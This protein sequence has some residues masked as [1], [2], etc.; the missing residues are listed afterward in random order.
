VARA[1]SVRQKRFDLLGYR[2]LD[3]GDPIDWHLD[4]VAGRRAPFVHW[5]RLAP[6]DPGMVG[7]SKVVWELNRHQWLLHLGQA[8]RFTGDE[9]YA[10][11]FAALIRDWMRKNP[12]GMGI[13]WASSL[14]AAFRIISWS[15]ALFL[16]RRSAALSPELFVEM[17]GSICAHAEH[18]EKYLSIYFAP[19]THLT[20][21]AL[22]L[23]YA[24]LIYPELQSAERWRSLGMKILTEQSE[25][26]VLPD[27]VYFE[28]ATC[29]QLYT[30]EIYLHF[31]ILAARNG[32][33]VPKSI[34][35]KLVK[36]LDFLVAVRRPDGSIPQIGDGD[37]GWLLPLA[38]RTAE[39]FRGLF[40]QAAVWFNRAD[41]AWAA[42]GPAPEI[43]WILGS[44]GVD[45]FDR[46]QPCPPQA[47]PS[48][49]FRDGGY[50]VMRSSWK[51]DSH[52]LIFDGGPLGCPVTGGHGH[53]DLLSIQCSVFGEPYLVDPGTYCYT[54][55]QAWR[56]YFRSS[57]AHSTVLVDGMGQ[58][59]PA[60]P[61]RWKARPRARLRQWLS[62]ESY[63][64]AEAEHDAFHRLPDPV[65]HRRRV[66]FVKPRYWIVVDD[67]E[68]SA[69]HRVELRFQFA[70]M[71]VGL[72]PNLWSR[73]RGTKG[74]GL[75]IKPFAP[76]ML[77]AGIHQGMDSPMA[78]WF[79]PAYG[80]R[81]PAP[82]LCYSASARLPLRVLTLLL[83]IEDPLAPVP[84]VSS[85][86]DGGPGP[87]GLLFKEWN[88]RIV[89]HRRE[90]LLDRG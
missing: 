43:P 41:Y 38:R 13:N 12:P 15:W 87:V 76:V 26:Q 88:E 1:N 31:V 24:G 72:E 34:E 25:R 9:R 16:F 11:T 46:L 85:V 53:A 39:D 84:A 69:D 20:G 68:G 14:E 29:Y 56:D 55:S 17:L 66:I 37:T 35:E 71:D 74:H 45:D 54:A 4:P 65:T 3:F 70:P 48:V 42:G 81:E 59:D 63:D 67:L 89:L 5:G 90:I 44:K 61:F 2:G 49:C 28:Q 73:A 33:T 64:L 62:T 30:A 40:A 78:G 50:A 86:L 80:L 22:G 7:D 60:G 8:Y 77:K 82:V 27:G 75:L 18:V 57:A 52:H 32:I 47:A 83:P 36:M 6:L 58:A 79:S 10:E 21:E 23:F 19:N 51:A